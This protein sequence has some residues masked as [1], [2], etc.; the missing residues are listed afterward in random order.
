MS[1]H[2]Q[3]A[4]LALRA[5]SL[6]AIGATSGIPVPEYSLSD[7]V[8]GIVHIGVG[9]FHRAHQAAVV[10]RLLSMGHA[11]DFAIC[12][13]GILPQDRRIA[14]VL[15]QQDGLYTLVLK[16]ADG[17][18]EGRIIGSIVDFF[19]APDEPAAVIERLAHP[20]T[21]I[22]SLTI[23]EG[24]Y[25]IDPVHGEFVADEPGVQHDLTAPEEPVTVFGY[26]I[27]ALALRRARGIPPFTV[28]SCDNIQGNGHVARKSFTAFARL[29][30]P[31][32]GDWVDRSVAFPNTMVDR[33]TPVTSD[34]D[35]ADV[36]TRFGIDDAW[37]VVAEPFF[38]WVVE[39]RFPA[40]RP[41]LELA[42]VDLV[43][44]VAPYEAMKLR[45]A[46]CTHQV[47]CYFGTL[48]GLRTADEALA[49]PRIRALAR[50]YLFDEALPT[51]TPIPGVDLGRYAET[52][53]ER[54]ANPAIGDTLA[55]I[56]AFGSDR[57]P[58]WLLPVVRDNLAAGRS[59][60]I[61]AAVCA[62]WARYCEGTDDAGRVV[63]VVDRLS[64]ELTATALGQRQHASAFI[65][66]RDLFGDLVDDPRFREPYLQA[67]HAL[68]Q[69][70]ADLA[71]GRL[72][73]ADHDHG[74]RPATA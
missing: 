19:F 21:R 27:A 12:G 62:A 66:R 14:D 45:C 35:R 7:L 38:Q 4:A 5:D 48:L 26:V 25:G 72:V 42:G 43:D 49:D 28:L 31:A 11:R 40:G 53:I 61:A 15:M 52:V 68:L 20:D 6:A 64:D 16:H 18:R 41:P 9:S 13:V 47:I 34:A 29:V 44:D 32:L 46:N 55:R 58:K 39:D 1:T 57:L 17:R 2:E 70:G 60:R 71:L 51:L 30:D 59:V 54:F 56:R 8:T 37:P 33:V 67:L 24:G 63:E 74:L 22:V 69:G 23:T 36:R 73:S 10:D 50:S 3:Q 65:E